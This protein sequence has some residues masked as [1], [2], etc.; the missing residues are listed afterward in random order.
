MTTKYIPPDIKCYRRLSLRGW[1]YYVAL[2][3]GGGEPISRTT[4]TYWKAARRMKKRKLTLE[5]D[6]LR[7]L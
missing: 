7:K 5:Q 4:Y 6:R 3:L 1:N 2:R